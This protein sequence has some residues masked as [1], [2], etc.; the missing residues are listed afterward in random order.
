M[1]IR[2]KVTGVLLIALIGL[3]GCKRSAGPAV[4]VEDPNS[5]LRE[6][7]EIAV[8]DWLGQSRVELDQRFEDWKNKAARLIELNRGDRQTH[9]LLPKLKPVLTFPVFQDARFSARAGISLPPYVEDGHKDP[10][11]AIHLARFGDADGALLLTNPADEAVRREI[12]SYRTDRNYPVEWT[13][14][15]ALAQFVAEMRLAGDDSQGAAMLI[16]LHEQLRIVLNPKAAA[17]P[18]G[19]VLLSGGRRA[20]DAANAAWE[21]A[22]KVG[23]ASD[24]TAAL[25]NW[26]EVAPPTSALSMGS[27][28]DRVERF[29]PSVGDAH[30]VT[31]LGPQA[32]RAFDLLGLPLP[33]D[34]LDGIVAFLNGEA[35]LSEI[36]FLYQPRAGQTYPDPGYLGQRIVGYSIT[37]QESATSKGT[38]REA[39]ACGTLNYDVT[40]V[41]RGSTIGGLVCITDAKAGPPA[42][43]LPAD[44]RDFG[45]VH[46]DR[47]FDQNRLAIA[48]EQ[49]SAESVTV[50]K[51]AEIRRVAPPGPER[52]H[53][54]DLPAAASL[55]LRRLEGFDLLSGLTLRWDRGQNAVALKL[56]AVPLWAA[57]GAPRFEPEFENNGGGNLALVWENAAMRYTLR[58]PHDEEQPVNFTADD[59]RGAKD[60]SERE[61]IAITFDR[62][63]RKV[64][65]AAGKPLQRLPRAFDEASGLRLGMTRAEVETALPA[66]QS[67][68]KMEIDGGWSVYFLSPPAGNGAATPQ[69]FFVRFGPNDKVV[70]LRL[71]YLERFL[72]KGDRTPTLLAHLSTRSGAPEV[73]PASW[74]GVWSDLPPQK[75]APILYRWHDDTTAM[76]LQ[77]DAGGAELTLRDLPA[78]KPTGFELPPLRFVSRGVEGC[79]LGDSRSAVLAHWKIAEPTKTSDGGIV[80]PMPKS[81]PYDAVVAY[82]ENGKVSLIRAYH[83]P[84]VN[85]IIPEVANALQQSWGR[86]IDHLGA[87]RRQDT[88]AD[89][90]V[91]GFGWHDDVT[92]VRTYAQDSDQGPRLYTE[93]REWSPTAPAKGVA[94]A[95]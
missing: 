37:G 5:H 74:S 16:H 75:P 50:T 71:R 14:L 30:S 94:T 6:D 55:T 21:Q 28:R 77:R 39:F 60:A 38:F 53:A 35:K 44:P 32:A 47:T 73:A 12:E 93:W 81:S 52:G 11:V 59:R 22:G 29:F 41:P 58:L 95:K 10:A 66:S 54:L 26:G 68:R 24:A 9:A 78:D 86:D 91:G 80:L 20:L 40:L 72:P 56:L 79:S 49:R 89:Q 84:K 46:F 61:K 62:D 25:G 13:R 43:L 1:S 87:I 57:Y 48:P 92:R 69:H 2:Y 82:F 63:Q 70:E 34:D 45:A 76:T 85:F 83:R 51:T 8:A 23:Y 88:P 19:S 18:L 15:V 31:A 17:G 27:G 36:A 33:A 3:S 42:A 90:L 4:V 67:L 7:S 65:M 64:R